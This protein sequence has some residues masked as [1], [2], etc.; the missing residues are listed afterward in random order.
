MLDGVF[1]V[2]CSD[3]TQRDMPERCGPWPTANQ[4]F[5]DW[6]N[7]C[8]FNKVLKRMHVKLNEQGL[9]ALDTLCIDSPQSERP[10]PHLGQAKKGGGRISGP[11]TWEKSGRVTNE[12][13]YG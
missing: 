7:Q 8:T 12:N 13:S 2:L 10:G 6:R 11:R 1:W 4:R 5:R 9:I 3:A